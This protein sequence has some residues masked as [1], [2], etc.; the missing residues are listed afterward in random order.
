MPRPSRYGKRGAPASRRPSRLDVEAD[1]THLRIVAVARR[2]FAEHGFNGTSVRDITT[3]AGVNLSAVTY[4]FQTKDLLYH[5][6]LRQVVGP[7]AGP[8]EMKARV[9][10][11]PPLERIDHI[12]LHFFTHIRANPD[13][14]AFMMRELSSGR[15]P[16][17]PIVEMMSRVLPAISGVIAEGQQKGEIRAGDPTLLSFSIIAQPVHLYLARG[18]IAAVAGLDVQDPAVMERIIEHVTFTVR[19]ALEAR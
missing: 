18:A 9:A 12:I 10:A 14:C 11:L 16:S 7:L 3:A 15:T 13:M 1:R 17:A 6:V 19:R 2:L 8:I 4:H 5:R